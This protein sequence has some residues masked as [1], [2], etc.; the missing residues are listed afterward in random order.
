MR[1]VKEEKIPALPDLQTHIRRDRESC[2]DS[3][4]EKLRMVNVHFRN[5][6][7]S[8]TQSLHT[9][10]AAESRFR[11]FLSYRPYIAPLCSY[12]NEFRPISAP[13]HFTDKMTE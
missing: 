8:R 1:L 3:M 5:A 9:L 7:I 10:F 12:L 13:T 6:C 4:F 2:W 11:C